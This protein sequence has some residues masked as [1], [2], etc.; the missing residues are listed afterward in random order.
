[1]DLKDVKLKYI[2]WI[3]LTCVRDKLEDFCELGN[4]LLVTQNT[5]KFF[6]SIGNTDC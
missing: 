6:T 1:M 5:E 3:L 4:G 2:D